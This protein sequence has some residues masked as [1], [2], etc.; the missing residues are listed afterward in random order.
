MGAYSEAMYAQAQDDF[1]AALTALFL[2][3]FQR[4]SD[5]LGQS[6][7]PEVLIAAIRALGTALVEGSAHLAQ[8]L[9]ADYPF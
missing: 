3:E 5:G 9:E 7:G 6:T 4:G 8:Q 2:E 1:S